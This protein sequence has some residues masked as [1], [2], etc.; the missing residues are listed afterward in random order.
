MK[1]YLSKY[2]YKLFFFPI[3]TLLPIFLISSCAK[4]KD[5]FN[6][7][8][9]IKA[10]NLYKE[11]KYEQATAFYKKYLLLFPKS[12][13][14]NYYLASVY[15]E[16]E[17][18]INAI[19]YFKKYL[20]LDPNSTDKEV[21]EKWIQASEESLYKKLEK[22][23]SDSDTKITITTDP[24]IEKQLEE[25][26]IKNQ[27]MKDFI[28]K[29]KDKIY[30]DNSTTIP[31]MESNA[32]EILGKTQYTV[33]EGDSLYRISKHIYGSG[34]YYKLIW[35]ANKSKFKNPSNIQPGDILSIPPLSNR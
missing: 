29:H 25:L 20:H 30:D 4:K 31:P 13:K 22:E 18:Y 32:P 27:K 16:K 3:I 11:G 33:K 19:Y 17:D 21:I 6:N 1:N 14:A 34:K 9:Y 23:Y 12:A 15:Q 8:Y 24:K 2:F 10:T 5:N 7:P 28:L 35:Q 26:R